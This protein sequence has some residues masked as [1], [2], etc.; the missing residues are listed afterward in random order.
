VSGV[1]D[2]DAEL[3]HYHAQLLSAVDIDADAR[4]LD[5]GC[6]AGQTSR[7][8]ARAASRGAVLGVDISA[9]MLA[10]ARRLAQLGGLA[11][12]WFELGDAQTHPFASGGFTVGLS[13]FGTMF[14]AEPSAAFANIAT[15][16]RPGARFVQL[17]WQ[18]SRRQEWDVALHEALTDAGCLPATPDGDTAFSL[19]DPDKVRALL[20]GAGFIDVRIAEVCEPVYYGADSEKALHALRSLRT[21]RELLHGLGNASTMRALE[22]L[23]TILDDHDKGSG[24]WFDSAAWLVSARRP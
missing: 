13:R 8:A 14:F 18:E 9:R 24:V 21:T 3:R 23:R 16:L 11:N 4:V 5:I 10:Q 15:A 20:T 19:A 22:R 17:V 1:F 12:A 7:A 6:G 2:Y